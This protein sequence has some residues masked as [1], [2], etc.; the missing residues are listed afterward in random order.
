MA[1]DR[2]AS[3]WTSALPWVSKFEW[4]TLRLVSPG[5]GEQRGL[6][7]GDALNG[8]NSFEAW[9]SQ[10]YGS[11]CNELHLLRPYDFRQLL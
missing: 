7:K 5:F 9:V 11:I 4:A 2:Y 1:S 10:Q 6:C 8:I 3:I